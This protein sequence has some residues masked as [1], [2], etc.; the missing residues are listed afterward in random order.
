[1]LDNKFTSH[2]RLVW[3]VRMEN[4]HYILN[5]FGASNDSLRLDSTYRDFLPSGNLIISVL[6][7]ANLRF[8]SSRTVAR[9]N[10]R[11]LA[12][13]PFYDFLQNIT[14]YGNPNLVE[15]RRSESLLAPKVLS[16]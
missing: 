16:I 6:K 15:T 11:E 7:N 9:P 12:N 8:S 2:I 5:T 10:Y 1:M 3:G 13:A 14:Y 4:Y